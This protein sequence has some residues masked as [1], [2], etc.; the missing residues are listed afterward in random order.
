[1]YLLHGDKYSVWVNMP[2]KHPIEF[3]SLNYFVNDQT[4]LRLA[5]HKNI[6]IICWSRFNKKLEEHRVDSFSVRKYIR[7]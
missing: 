5:W 2:D 1:M 7:R 3:Y 4:I 6:G